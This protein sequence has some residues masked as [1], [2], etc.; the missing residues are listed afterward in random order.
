MNKKKVIS[1]GLEHRFFQFDGK[2]YTKLS[3]SYLYWKDY[4]AFFDEVKVI[5]RVKQ[6]ESIDPSYKRV[7]GKNVSFYPMPYYVGIKDFILNFHSLIYHSYLVTRSSEALLL[8]SGNISNLLW[9]FSMLKKKPYLR[10]YPGNI[11]EGVLG[12]GGKSLLNSTIA[13]LLNAVA[14]IQAR[15]SVANSYVSEYCKWLYP[16]KGNNSFIFSSFNADEIVTRKVITD[17]AVPELVCV[18]RLEGEKGHRDLIESISF[19]DMDV[20]LSIIGDGS[21]KYNL[22][23]Y[24]ESLGV[25][26]NFMGSITDRTILFDK[27]SKSDLFVLPSHTEGMPRALLEAMAIGLPCIGTSVGGIPEVLDKSMLFLPNKPESCAHKI[28]MLMSN[29]DLAGE[30]SKRNLSFINCSYSK[31]SMDERKLRF[32]SELYK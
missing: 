31:K 19:L 21:Q 10:E 6:V 23:Q 15:Y 28:T 29:S 4:L 12:Y 8:R 11:E 32:W 17:N 30:Q 26:V 18:G 2:V 14:K 7:D 1:V 5:A 27:L 24:A 25:K 20:N 3:F 22:E 13:K 9:V 16:S